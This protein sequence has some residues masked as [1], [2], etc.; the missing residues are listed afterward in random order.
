[1]ILLD[2]IEEVNADDPEYD[3]EADLDIVDEGPLIRLLD[4]MLDTP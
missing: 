3:F 2:L 1:M 4:E